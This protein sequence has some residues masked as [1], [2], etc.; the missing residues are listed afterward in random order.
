[1]T[2]DLTDALCAAGTGRGTPLIIDHLDYGRRLFLR[3]ESEPWTDS[4]QFVNF[5]GQAQ[6]LLRPDAALLDLGRLYGHFVAERPELRASMTARSRTGYALKTLLADASAAAMAVDLVGAVSQ[7]S[8]LPLVLQIPSTLTWLSH[9][10]RQVGSGDLDGIGPEH[11]ENLSI[12]LADWLRRFADL[13]VTMLMLDGRRTACGELPEDEMGYYAPVS[14]T[15][16]HYR[17]TL[18]LRHDHRVEVANSEI[19][20]AVVPAGFWSDASTSAPPAD[21]RLTE[22]PASA[23]PET[24]LAR[25]VDLA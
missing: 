21:F 19:T 17:W 25:L 11:A 20:G 5:F 12:Y 10:E 3:G 24:V 15:T 16:E 22:I 7:T 2:A 23:A 6:A 14:N 4:A 8:K 18:G 9:I 1:M 13:P